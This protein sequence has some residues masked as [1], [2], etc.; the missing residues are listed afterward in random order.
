M[1]RT[2]LVKKPTITTP[3]AT[4]GTGLSLTQNLM[5]AVQTTE[6]P[7]T[8]DQTATVPAGGNGSST[9]QDSCDEETNGNK[10]SDGNNS[11]DEHEDREA[12]A[13]KHEGGGTRDATTN[14][15]MVPTTTF[16]PFLQQ[17]MTTLARMDARMEH[18]NAEAATLRAQQPVVPTTSGQMTQPPATTA[19]THPVQS[20][21]DRRVVHQSEDRDDDDGDGSSSSDSDSSNRSD[22]SNDDDSRPPVARQP[23][24]IS[25]NRSSQR[26]RRRTIRDLDLLTFLPTPQTSVSTWIARVELA[27]T[28]ARISGRGEWADQELYYIMGPKLL[29]IA[30]RWW[31]QLD[32]NVLDR[33]RTWSTLK[34]LLTNPYG[35]LPDKSMAAWRVG[36]RRMADFAATLRDLCGNNRVKERQ[37]YRSIDQTTRALVRQ[38]RPKIRTLEAAVEKSTE[39]SDRIYNVAQEMEIIEIG[40]RNR[41]GNVCGP[42]EWYDGP[43]AMILDVESGALDDDGKLAFFTSLQ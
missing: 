25:V 11:T 19:P 32:R 33:D 28:G 10:S 2:K 42:Y 18:L 41:T 12:D 40:L 15:D 23:A 39:I 31:I 37:F 16:A 22:D 5:V 9:R 6:D 13:D 29:E 36:Q 35:E 43:V 21:T 20:D 3:S 7:G 24:T 27:L 1:A 17:L 30:G 4:A 8:S 26:N 34:T 14:A 38:Y